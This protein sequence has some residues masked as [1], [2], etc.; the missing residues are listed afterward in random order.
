M[1]A[2]QRIKRPRTHSHHWKLYPSK[3]L[4]AW[5]LLILITSTTAASTWILLQ[6]IGGTTPFA[7]IYEKLVTA[8]ALAAAVTGGTHFA[9]VRR[10][11]RTIE[12]DEDKTVSPWLPIN[13]SF[14]SM[15][16]TALSRFDSPLLEAL[17]SARLKFS[18]KH[19]LLCQ[20]DPTGSVY[21]KLL[22]DTTS[23]NIRL[24]SSFAPARFIRIDKSDDTQGALL[25]L[26]CRS[27][28]ARYVASLACTNNS[29]AQPLFDPKWSECIVPIKGISAP[30]IPL[31]HNICS[32]DVIAIGLRRVDDPTFGVDGF[33][34]YQ[35]FPLLPSCQHFSGQDAQ[36]QSVA[37][38]LAQLQTHIAAIDTSDVPKHKQ[39]AKFIIDTQPG[40]TDQQHPVRKVRATV[41]EFRE[42]WTRIL[43]HLNSQD[44]DGMSSLLRSKLSQ[45]FGA[46]RRSAL[47]RVTECISVTDGLVQE[48]DSSNYILLHDVHPH[49]VIFSDDRCE[50]ILDYSWIGRFNHGVVLA[51]ALHRF[52]RE[53]VRL[54]LQRDGSTRDIEQHCADTS[55]VFMS[56][57]FAGMR[58]SHLSLPPNFHRKLY[59]YIMYSNLDKLISA[60]EYALEIKF[61]LGGRSKPRLN[62]EVRKFIRFLSEAEVFGRAHARNVRSLKF[63][64]AES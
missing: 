7:D 58:G 36:L 26:K 47:E 45:T 29:V 52:C 30:T 27:E 1:I 11:E 63:T 38:K 21:E 59:E 15:R 40:R 61:D 6:A 19:A 41:L 37:H 25:D 8:L 49:N 57:Y 34:W 28:L 24:L 39:L 31:P 56:N 18:Y 53:T 22:E 14:S 50:L 35:E 43:E 64:D 9:E 55:A 23:E 5:L 17:E 32:E 20:L 3:T 13:H 46:D 42:R 51:S 16:W 54:R 10:T 33:R 44:S 4:A 60:V 48:R 62:G 12:E 2:T